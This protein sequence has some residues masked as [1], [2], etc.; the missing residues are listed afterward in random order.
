MSSFSAWWLWTDRPI[1][2]IRQQ[3]LLG[4]AAS[5]PLKLTALLSPE[6]A[7]PFSDA[8]II[9]GPEKTKRGSACLLASFCLLKQQGVSSS[10]QPGLDYSGHLHRYV[11]MPFDVPFPSLCPKFSFEVTGPPDPPAAREAG[12]SMYN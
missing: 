3:F 7:F 8:D 12:L 2:D 11:F 10:G 6:A 9:L 5:G 4:E 1:S